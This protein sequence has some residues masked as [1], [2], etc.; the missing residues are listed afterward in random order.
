MAPVASSVRTL[1][2]FLCALFS[3]S[4][5]TVQQAEALSGPSSHNHSKD[6]WWLYLHCQKREPQ[7]NVR[8]EGSHLASLR[9]RWTARGMGGG[10]VWGWRRR[11]EAWGG[12]RKDLHFDKGVRST[13][14]NLEPFIKVFLPTSL[15]CLSPSHSS[16][17]ST[18]ANPTQET[19]KS[20]QHLSFLWCRST[21]KTR[22]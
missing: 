6:P 16:T 17:H 3:F 11:L 5:K 20:L 21:L 18:L 12:D 8:K 2:L 10:G 13:R 19:G 22:D 4:W 9:A 1:G 7:Q 15:D 14:P